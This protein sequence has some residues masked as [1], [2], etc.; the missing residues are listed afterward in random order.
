MTATIAATVEPTAIVVTP[1]T[2]A[3]ATKAVAAKKRKSE[4]PVVNVKPAP[5]KPTAKTVAPPVVAEPTDAPIV[6]STDAQLAEAAANDAADAA[7]KVAAKK[8]KRKAAR[9]ARLAK[10]TDDEKAARKTK[11]AAAR[12]KRLAGLTDEQKSARAAARKASRAKRVAAKPL[13]PTKR[14]AAIVAMLEALPGDEVYRV[15]TLREM[16]EKALAEV[17]A[18]VA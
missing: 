18:T 7:V 11:R 8:A 6:V 15:D 14:N 10:M 3:D 17:A 4:T 12:T 9:V 16:F 2:V 1:A 5:K 13:A